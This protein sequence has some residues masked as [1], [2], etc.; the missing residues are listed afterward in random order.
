LA[1]TAD[2]KRLVPYDDK[3]ARFLFSSPGKTIPDALAKK[4]GLVDGSIPGSKKVKSET[5]TGKPKIDEKDAAIAGEEKTAKKIADAAEAA[6]KEP[7]LPNI[8]GDDEKADGSASESVDEETEEDDE[9]KKEQEKPDDKQRKGKPE[10]K[11]YKGEN[12]GGKE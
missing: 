2:K 10:N 6:S 5:E 1:Y 3:E 9:V 7:P 4:Y 8:P 12:K 11:G